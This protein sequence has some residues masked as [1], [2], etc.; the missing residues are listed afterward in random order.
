MSIVCPALRPLHPP[1]V[2]DVVT[3]SVRVTVLPLNV[4][5]ALMIGPVTKDTSAR[6]AAPRATFSS[7]LNDTRRYTLPLVVFTVSPRLIR[8][9]PSLERCVVAVGVLRQKTFNV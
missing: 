2:D 7:S 3:Q 9:V 1:H 6:S 8:T 4:T 5:V